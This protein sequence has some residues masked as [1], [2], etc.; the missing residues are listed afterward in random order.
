MTFKKITFLAVTLILVTSCGIKYGFKQTSIPDNV[1]T[2]QVDF[3]GNLDPIEPGIERTFTLN[4]QD[5]IQDQTRLSIVNSGG[6][7]IYQGEITRYYIAPMTA[8]AN[9]TASQNRLTI[10]VNVR[11]TNTK[12]EE[13]SFEK[14]FSFFYDYP[15]NVLLN[16]SALDEALDVIFTQITQDIVNETLTSW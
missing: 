1:N 9:N 5:L 6:D 8:T 7:Y 10:E 13:Q 4:L 12:D 2:F 15:A 14:K 16:G 3:F 11:F